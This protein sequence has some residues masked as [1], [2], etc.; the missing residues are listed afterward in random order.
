MERVEHLLGI[1]TALRT[2]FPHNS[3]MDAQWMRRTNRYFRRRSPLATI[4]EDGIEGLIRVR[5][6]LD[7]AYAWTLTG[8]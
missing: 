7:C 6:H 3:R 2:T 8:H 1:A 5:S 4:F